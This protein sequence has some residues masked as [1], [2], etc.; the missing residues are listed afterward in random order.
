MTPTEVAKEVGCDVILYRRIELG[1][2]LPTFD[3]AVAIHRV[4]CFDANAA[5]RWLWH[6]G[7]RKLDT[8]FL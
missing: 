6:K 4:L 7:D 5:F 1:A 2:E 3:V 8:N